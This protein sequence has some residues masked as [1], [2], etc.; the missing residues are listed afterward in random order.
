MGYTVKEL[1]S[2]LREE[3]KASSGAAARGKSVTK[4]HNL[5]HRETRS[6]FDKTKVKTELYFLLTLYEY[7]QLDLDAVS[8][9]IPRLN[10]R[11]VACS[12]RSRI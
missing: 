9:G 6:L 1:V 8:A 3:E 5:P 12:H 2:T 10:R 7:E 11:F 4:P